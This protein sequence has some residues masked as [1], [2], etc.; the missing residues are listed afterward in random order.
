MPC[1]PKDKRRRIAMLRIVAFDLD[2]TIADT[3]PMCIKA[4][5]NGVSP[6]TDHELTEEEI[7]QTFGLNEVGMVKAVVSQH[8]ETAVENFYIQYES[9]HNEV[10]DVFPGIL[11][12]F[13][14]LKKK[15]II[16]ALITGKGK[17]SCTITLEKLGISNAFDEILYGSEI[18]PNKKENIEYLIQKYNIS[19]REFCYIGDTVQDIQTCQKAGVSCLSAAWQKN[20]NA[21]A[22]EMEN[23]NCVFSCVQDIYNYFELNFPTIGPT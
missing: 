4:F 9:L 16:L 13:S 3:I 12:L 10:T 2:G 7:L 8:W 18:A 14:L 20:A 19:R 21:T 5:R 23:P 17:Q 22:L 15:K 11:K 6:Y 1:N